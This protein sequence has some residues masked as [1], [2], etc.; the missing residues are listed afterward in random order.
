ML[1]H[2]IAAPRTATERDAN[3]PPPCRAW[4]TDDAPG[5]RLSYWIEVLGEAIFEL[6]IEVP[7][8]DEFHAR[9]R[10]YPLGACELSLIEVDGQ[11]VH[12][13]RENI[14]RSS[15]A[16]FDLIF[17]RRG[18]MQ[19]QQHGRSAEIGD[20][21]CVLVDS[22]AEYEFLTSPRSEHLVLHLP[23][24]W[25]KT[26]A[27]SPEDGTV[28]P[29]TAATPWGGALTATLSALAA[30]P[31]DSLLL[32]RQMLANQV[33]SL[34]SLAIGAPDRSSTKHARRLYERLLEEL[35]ERAHEPD[36]SAAGLAAAFNVST[37]YLHRLFAAAGTTY[38]HELYRV[39]L[40]RAA[41]LLSDGRFANTSISEIGARSGFSD[42]S[43]FA[44]RFREKFKATP[45][46][47][48][49][50]AGAARA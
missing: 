41:R 46:A 12:R 42:P 21:G 1:I 26:L 27:P 33:G 24:T 20:G 39:R 48:R 43:H 35:D 18:P 17:V 5:D 38:G 37:R 25:L 50:G 23:E 32:P 7:Q 19:I 15:K 31:I 30:E 16:Q 4:T 22:Q 29:I 34:L 9:L 8:R 49:G 40:E 11:V 44:R 14:S 6:K 45:G 3:V 2:K 28:R 47:Y 10:Q 13:T 36:L